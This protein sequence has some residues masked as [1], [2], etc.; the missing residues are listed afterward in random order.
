MVQDIFLVAVEEDLKLQVE[1]MVQVVLVAVEEQDADQ[2]DQEMGQ[3]ELL[4]QAVV[5]EVA[6]EVNQEVILV[7][8]VALVAPK[9]QTVCCK[10]RARIRGIL[11]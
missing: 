1:V 6:L 3:Q 7:R 9:E 10:V 8:Q 11:S 5:E 4:T 2:T